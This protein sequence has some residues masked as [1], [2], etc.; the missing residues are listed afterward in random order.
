MVQR[1]ST[2]VS[3]LQAMEDL[4]KTIGFSE[5][6]SE[7]NSGST[8][9]DLDAVSAPYKLMREMHLPLVRV[10]QKRD[11]MLIEGLRKIGFQCDY[12]EDEAGLFANY[13]RNFSGDYIDLG[14]SQLLITGK[15]KLKSRVSVTELRPHSVVFDDGTEVPADLVVYATGY[16]PMTNWVT[17]L[18]SEEVSNKVGRVWGLGSGFGKDTGPWEG[19]IRNMW[20]P[21]HQPGLWF[22]GGGLN[23]TRIFSAYLAVQIKVRQLGISIQ[24]YGMGKVHHLC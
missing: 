8:K 17:K 19:E 14:A 18:I 15:I 7:S 22:H 12:C 23:H 4:F 6:N 16:G 9:C 13:A 11:S 20:K 5:E 24:V 2:I 21:T 1:G 10:M 3:S